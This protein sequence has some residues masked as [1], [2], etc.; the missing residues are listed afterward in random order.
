MFGTH[1][2]LCKSMRYVLEMVEPCTITFLVTFCFF[3]DYVVQI[4]GKARM[5]FQLLMKMSDTY[6]PKI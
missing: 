4:S 1:A 5:C 3:K 2:R 6:L